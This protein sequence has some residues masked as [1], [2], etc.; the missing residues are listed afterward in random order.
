MSGPPHIP[1][2]RPTSGRRAG[3][4]TPG[5]P[6]ESEYVA[7]IEARL[8]ELASAPLILSPRD[9]ERVRGWYRRAI[10]IEVVLR[11]LTDA[12]GRPAALSPP[13]PAESPATSK[14][15]RRR[16]AR[17]AADI[18]GGFP[19]LHR[20]PYSLAYCERAVEQRWKSQREGA[21]GRS[22][23]SGPGSARVR[24]VVH[25][26]AREV[27]A[28]ARTARLNPSHRSLAPILRGLAGRLRT[29]ARTLGAGADPV[30]EAAAAL[31]QTE[32]VLHIDL[33]TALAG[34]WDRLCEEEGRRLGARL[35]HMNR[36]AARTT[37]EASV[38][39]RTRAELGIP[40]IDPGALHAR[41]LS[42]SAG[43]AR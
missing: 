20:R 40:P 32:A 27:V 41:L 28:A 10:P 35:A 6:P 24:S 11:A 21:V 4:P 29:A 16:G 17:A 1:D 9:W 8:S 38:L 34:E 15:R 42:R 13:A 37:I 26:L 23:P 33:R 12:L 3:A 31:L 39:R 43:R 19:G 30:G 36:A 5:L 18:E 14:A 22:T 25:E 2:R 7:A